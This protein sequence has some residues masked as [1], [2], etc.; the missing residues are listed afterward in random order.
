MDAIPFD[1]FGTGR[2]PAIHFAHANGFPPLTYR[3]FLSQLQA[4]GDIVAT[5]LRPLWPDATPASLKSW[6]GLADDI[7]RQI[8]DRGWHGVIGMGHSMGGVATMYASLRRPSLFRALVLIEPVF[9]PVNTLTALRG[10][11]E[12]AAADTP[13]VRSAL[14]RRDRWVSRDDAWRR[15]RTKRVFARWPDAILW[16]YVNHAVVPDGDEHALAYSKQWEAR[17]YSLAPTDVWE[18]IPQI[19][20]PTLAL[21]G[22][23]TDT[24]TDASWDLWQRLQ[25][26][27]TFVELPDCGH[28]LTHERPD[29]VADAIRQWL[30]TLPA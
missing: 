9:L 29:A 3:R 13:L 12:E 18:L 8:D 19:E 2:Q 16:D 26:D 23:A 10:L 14:M 15:F 7:I 24:I 6:H 22:A 27:A 21:R 11:P 25:P 30:A 4:E 28:L 20:R 5:H 1:A 17:I